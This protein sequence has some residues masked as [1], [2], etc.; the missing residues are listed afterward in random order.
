MDQEEE[1]PLLLYVSFIPSLVV[2]MNIFEGDVMQA[3]VVDKER[4]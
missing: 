2:E 1:S 3:R 4:I